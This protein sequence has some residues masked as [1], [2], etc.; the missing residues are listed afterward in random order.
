ME[1][2]VGTYPAWMLSGARAGINARVVESQAQGSRVLV[3]P[4]ILGPSVHFSEPWLVIYGMKTP[5]QGGV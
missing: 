2:G 4:L 5:A 1:R 3:L